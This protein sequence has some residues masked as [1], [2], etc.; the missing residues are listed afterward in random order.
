[1]DHPLVNFH[2]KTPHVLPKKAKTYHQNFRNICFPAFVLNFGFYAILQH[3]AISC[4][5]FYGTHAVLPKEV[6][7]LPPK[8]QKHLFSFWGFVS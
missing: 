8:F 1:M 5:H 4:P 3:I 2:L 7:Y 6:M